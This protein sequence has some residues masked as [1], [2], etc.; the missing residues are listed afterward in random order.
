L[1]P[2]KVLPKP[3]LSMNDNISTAVI[4]DI[5]QLVALINSAFRG[6]DSKK[7]W[8]TEATLIDGDR[9]IDEPEL[10]RMIE[11]PNGTIKKYSLDGKIVGCVYLEVRGPELYLGALSVSPEIQARGLGKKMLKYAHYFA[12]E[13][14]CSS[15]VMLVVSVRKEL[16]D[17]YLRHGY[18]LTSETRPFP[19]DDKFG[20]PRQTLEFVVLRKTLKAG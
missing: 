8:T 10:Q 6:E 15:I 3:A 7:G 19:T 18:L 5:P 17:W 9:R 16:I 2:R 4:E 1:G 14:K 13:K 20:T 11:N 12:L